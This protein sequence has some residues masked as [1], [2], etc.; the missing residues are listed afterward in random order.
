MNENNV[1]KL[2]FELR[3]VDSA[4]VIANAILFIPNSKI[5]SADI[6]GTMGYDCYR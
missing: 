2:A 6:C 4:R 5:I 1:S 3:A